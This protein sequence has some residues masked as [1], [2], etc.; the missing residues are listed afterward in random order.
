MSIVLYSNKNCPF[1][2]RA[3][4]AL[5]LSNISYELIEVDFANK[6]AKLLELSPKGTVP[7]LVLE[8][9]K[10][11]DE[12][13]EIVAEFCDYPGNFSDKHMAMDFVSNLIKDYRAMKYDND[14]LAKERCLKTIKEF[15]TNL[16]KTKYLYADKPSIV[17][18]A[19]F[20]FINAFFK[21]DE[22]LVITLPNLKTMVDS[23][24]KLT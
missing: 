22:S 2:M 10:V 8:D 6:P 1:C 11:I 15:E 13:I 5:A 9:G 21:L 23:L 24:M 7:V 18:I 4:A 14:M 16:L 17:D 12:S 3:R 19:L 20:P